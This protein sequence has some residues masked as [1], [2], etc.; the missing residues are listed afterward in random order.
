MVTEQDKRRINRI[1]GH[2]AAG[3][4]EGGNRY[5]KGPELA[6]AAEMLA[7]LRFPDLDLSHLHTA[8]GVTAAALTT[9]AGSGRRLKRQPSV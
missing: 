7:R 3:E 6:A 2:T 5:D 4:G 8:E 9:A 1:V